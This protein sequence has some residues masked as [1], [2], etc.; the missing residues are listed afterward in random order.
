MIYKSRKLKQYIVSFFVIMFI[1]FIW[2]GWPNAPYKEFIL[3]NIIAPI[4]LT[5]IVVLW[6]KFRI[7]EKN[8]D[9]FECFAII[10]LMFFVL[11]CLIGQAYQN[12]SLGVVFWHVPTIMVINF[13]K[14]LNLFI[15]PLVV[16]FFIDRFISELEKMER[17]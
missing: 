1:G 5:F 2:L 17:S 12:W 8:R 6:R 7:G 13:D 9:K 4:F 10:S 16:G 11:V 3:E 14:I 15:V